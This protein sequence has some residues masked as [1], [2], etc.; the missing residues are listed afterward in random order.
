MTAVRLFRIRIFLF[1]KE[2]YMALPF[3]LSSDSKKEHFANKY[4]PVCSVYSDP[5]HPHGECCC[6]NTLHDEYFVFSYL[7]GGITNIFYAEPVCAGKLLFYTNQ[8]IPPKFNPFLDEKSGVLQL[9]SQVSKQNK[10]PYART[11]THTVARNFINQEFLDASAL[12]LY[13]QNP[14]YNNWVLDMH[15]Q[16]QAA[17]FKPVTDRIVEYFNDLVYALCVKHESKNLRTLIQE[18]YPNQTP[19]NY[20]FPYLEGLLRKQRI[21]SFL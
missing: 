8:P 21:V 5:P 3:L 15:G 1:A 17:P 6:G 18:L 16:F 12:F 14:H 4:S 11:N 10:I 2:I 19:R 20:T 7:D 9:D 13:M